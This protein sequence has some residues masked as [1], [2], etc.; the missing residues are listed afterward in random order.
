MRTVN[1]DKIHTYISMV[2]M[3]WRYFF[4]ITGEVTTVTVSSGWACADPG[5][6]A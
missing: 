4:S 5:V 6:T 1:S 2:L 3:Q